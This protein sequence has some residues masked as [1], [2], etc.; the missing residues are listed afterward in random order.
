M[1]SWRPAS[2]IEPVSPIVSSNRILPGPIA[3][4][5]PRSTRNVSLAMRHSPRDR[6]FRLDGARCRVS[7]IE[8]RMGHD[9]NQAPGGRAAAAA[10]IAWLDAQASPL[11][12]EDVMLVETAG[13]VTAG[14][15]M[16]ASAVPPLDRA[17]ID[18]VA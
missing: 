15:V 10:A 14:A 11:A 5:G 12:P 17:M 1:P 7:D 6:P 3:W 18:G 16:A 4:S 8:N 9:T 2:E 13:R